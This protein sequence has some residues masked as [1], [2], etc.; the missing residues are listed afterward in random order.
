MFLALIFPFTTFFLPEEATTWKI[1]NQFEKKHIMPVK[2]EAW[3]GFTNA[4]FGKS[5]EIDDTIKKLDTTQPYF[6][7]L[8][9]KHLWQKHGA[10]IEIYSSIK[11][12]FFKAKL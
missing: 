2:K 8:K 6:S 9:I 1:G 11:D 10:K 5:S 3:F 12:Y 7:S 4:T